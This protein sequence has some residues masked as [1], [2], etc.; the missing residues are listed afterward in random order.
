M[1]RRENQAEQVV[2]DVVI[3]RGNVIGHGI[4]LLLLEFA[5]EFAVLAFEERAAA[6]RSIARCFAAV[7]SHAPGFDGMPSRRPLFERGDESVVSEILGGADVTRDAR[8]AGDQ[9]RRFD[10]PDSVNC[11]VDGC[12]S[13]LACEFVE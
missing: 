13:G 5:A 6:E 9:A 10:A 3:E 8:Q 12:V 2:A 1:A 11:G 7:I 4:F